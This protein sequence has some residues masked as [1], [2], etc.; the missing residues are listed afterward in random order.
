MPM[1][2]TSQTHPVPVTL[3]TGFLGSGK[4]TQLNAVLRNPAFAGTLVIVNEFGDVGLDHLLV[5]SAED[6]VL[7]LDSGCLCCASSGNLRDTLIDLFV[8]RNTGAIPPFDRI[9]IE[10]S[11]LAHPGPLTATLIGDSALLSR[12]KLSQVLTIVDAANGADTLMTYQE[13]RDQVAMADTLVIGKTDTASPLQIQQLAEMLGG[14]NPHAP[15]HQWQIGQDTSHVLAPNSSAQGTVLAHPEVW[16]ENLMGSRH[17]ATKDAKPASLWASDASNS[18]RLAAFTH[19][20]A[21]Q[22]IQTYTLRFGKN[23]ISW[24]AYAALTQALSQTFGRMLLRCKGLLRLQGEDPWIIQGVQGY[25]AKPTRLPGH[26]AWNENSF[27]VC[28]G[29]A[30]SAESLNAITAQIPEF[31]DLVISSTQPLEKTNG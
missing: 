1:V 27:L 30:L 2:S 10:T 6:Q 7:L 23:P 3:I 11:G 29:A 12:C 16:I 19:S 31:S 25:F 14:L 5:D 15:I 24:P 4:T 8:R 17:L 20:S 28:I 21:F 9:M 13:A 22:S 18:S 26:Q